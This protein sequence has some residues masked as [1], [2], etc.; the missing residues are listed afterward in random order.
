MPKIIELA[1]PWIVVCS[2]DDAI[3]ARRHLQRGLENPNREFFHGDKRVAQYRETGQI[4][5]PESYAAPQ[6]DVPTIHVSTDGEYAP[7]IDEVVKQMQSIKP[8]TQG[9]LDS[10]LQSL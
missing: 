10:G 9:G 5:S 4:L 8:D 1:S 6:F 7:C 2:I 3:A